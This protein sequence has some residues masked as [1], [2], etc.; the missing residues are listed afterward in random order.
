MSQNVITGI[1][2]PE[3]IK[4]HG[5]QM[6]VRGSYPQGFPAGAIV[7]STDGRPNDGA[8]SASYGVTEGKYAY[9][10]IGRT[11]KVYQNFSLEHWGEHAGPT[12][13]P[14]LGNKLSTKLVGIE[15]VSAGHLKKIN[16]NTFRPWYNDKPTRPVPKPEDDFRAEDVRYRDA[17]GSRS[18]FGYQTAGH[19]H[20]FTTEQ[21]TALIKLLKWLHEH[22]P[23][24]F[25]Y[26]NVLG[27]DEA[28]VDEDREY[29]RKQDPGAGLSVPMAVFRSR[30]TQA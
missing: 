22:R 27:H 13:H 5:G 4:F 24:I 23:L 15:V 29:G 17:I 8:Q 3:A 21:E 20:K 16:D 18:N 25:K 28:A 19:Y 12:L 14:T 2:Y 7:H 10:V 26:E 9:F 30:L 1:F 11:G 6:R